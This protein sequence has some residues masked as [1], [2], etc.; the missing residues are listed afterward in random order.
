M[1]S[2]SPDIATDRP[3]PLTF[4]LP[5]GLIGGLVWLCVLLTRVPTW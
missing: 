5:A 4:V 3:C 2:Q 1:Q